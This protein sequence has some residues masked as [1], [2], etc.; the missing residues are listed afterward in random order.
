MHR[1]VLLGTGTAVGKTHVAATLAHALHSAHPAA[2]ILPLK[3][4]ET[5]YPPTLDRPPPG[6]D[7]ATLEAAAANV[8]LPRPHPLFTHPEPLSP[9]LAARRAATTLH[10]PTLTEWVAHA[11]HDATLHHPSPSPH[12]WTLVETPGGALSP[13]SPSANN[14]AFA[15]A[16]EPATWILVAPDTLGVLHDLTACLHAMR[17][18]ARLPDHTVLTAARP[19]DLSTGTNATELARLRIATISTTFS[20]H[21]PSAPNQLAAAVLRHPP[22]FPL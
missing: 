5:G 16:L 9:H 15:Q 21:D 14:L 4:I 13:L 17:T 22:P 20:P 11:E 19:P 12:G 1:L 6:S 8:R 18:T 3:P 7:A 10:L 2:P